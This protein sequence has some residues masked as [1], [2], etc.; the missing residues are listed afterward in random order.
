MP[1]WLA[2]DQSL[3]STGFALWN[4]ESELPFLGHWKLAPDMTWRARGY[5][6]L[7]K[8]M[9]DLHRVSTLERIIYE[10]PLSQASL[11][12]GTSIA[13]VQMLAGLAAHIES[14]AEAVGA[15]HHAVNIASWRKHF[16]GSMKRGTKTPDLKAMTRTRCR[17]FGADPANFDESDAFGILDYELSMNGVIPP[18]RAGAILQRELSP[19]T[20]GR[21]LRD[22]RL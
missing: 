16:I 2:L 14:F 8:N 21:A 22:A 5:V 19:S 18:W 10:E 15:R 12:G 9:M 11:Q 6:R 4:G 20:D 17:E 3:S 1:T 13:T 7:H